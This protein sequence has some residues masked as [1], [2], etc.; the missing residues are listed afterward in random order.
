MIESESRLIF[1]FTAIVGQEKAKLALLCNA[2]NPMIGG[3]LLSG[4]KGTGKST[5][6]RALAD[7]LPEI[8]IVKGC[9]FNCNPY[10][11]LEMC[12]VCREK[13]NNGEIEIERRKMRVVDL[14]LS[15]TVDRLVGTI[16]IEKALKE[17]IRALQPGILAE[18]NRNI[19]YIDEVNLLD[20]YIA[21]VLLDAA[22]MGWNIVER[23]GVSLRHPSR[24]I[25]VGSMNPEEGELR[26]QILDRFGLY[27]QI[28]AVRDVEQ[29]MEIVR[30]VEE[31]QADPMGFRKKFES[32]QRELREKVERARK[33]VNSVEIDD[34]LLKLLVKTIIESGIKTHRAEIVTVRTAKAIAALDGRK[35][36]SFEDLKK[37]MELALPH[38]LKDKPFEKIVPPPSNQHDKKDDRKDNGKGQ[39]EE[40]SVPTAQEAPIREDN[41]GGQKGE[42]KNHSHQDSGGVGNAES[43]FDSVNVSVELPMGETSFADRVSRGSR[44]EKA[45][46]I[47]YPQGYPI[48]YVPGKFSNDVDIVATIRSAVTNGRRIICDEDIRVKVR[49]A[50]LP[51]LTVILLDA[52]GSMA[53]M[54]RIMIAK[55]I[56]KKLIE[57]S[58]IKRDFLSLVSFRGY[59]AEVLV[60]PTK[61]YS[62]VLDALKNVAIGGRTPLA[63]ALYTLLVIA[64]GFK[65]KNRNSIV[66][67]I[68]ITDG[69]A[70]TTLY[71]KSIKEDL[72]ILA[73]A[74]KKSGIKLEIYDTRVV[75]IDPSPSYIEFLASALNAKVHKANEK[76]HHLSCRCGEI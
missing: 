30:R 43:W 39:K 37:A 10:N 56:A 9:P 14:P 21:D 15:I 6:V 32:K 20:D 58:Y 73:S 67:G 51:R 36:V 12:E 23:E 28:E 40:A 41:S 8:E 61:R 60:P 76:L 5:M 45:I 50:R 16:D 4:D 54:R 55:G 25:L 63:S 31:F 69:K 13:V 49:R 3:V 44:D 1:P 38:R 68:L 59:S 35:K 65:L 75:D 53:A 24:F 74:M 62:A 72:Q 11:E 66:R 7:V 57:N 47:G 22:A 18:A 48:S 26:P 17:G 2:V 42:K 52:S 33:I 71:K 29:R 46:I 27:V 70:N 34:D 19:L 64:R